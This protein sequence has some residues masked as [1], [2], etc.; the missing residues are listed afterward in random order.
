MVLAKN[1]WPCAQVTWLVQEGLERKLKLFDSEN[2]ALA[3]S[4]HCSHAMVWPVVGMD[5]LQPL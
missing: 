4:S 5:F 1:D 3:A 2:S